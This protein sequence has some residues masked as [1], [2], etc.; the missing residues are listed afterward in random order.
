[1]DEC[2]RFEVRIS[3]P[4]E[5]AAG[6]PH[7]LGFRP[8]ESVVLIGLGGASGGRVGLTVR[9]DIP[10]PRHAA[11][12]AG[13]LAR[14]VATDEPA[15]VLVAV[16]SEA[17]DVPA[18]PGGVDLP[19]RDLVHELVVTLAAEDIP[20]RD[21]LLVR[22]GRWWS[23]DCPHPCCAPD[24]GTPLPAGVSELEAASVAAGQV[25]AQSRE[26]L[27]TRL[28]SL[29]RVDREVVRAASLT[30]AAAR[31]ARAQDAG[32]TSWS[33]RHGARS[34]RRSSSARSG[35]RWRRPA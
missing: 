11:A 23:Y 34:R 14:G 1:V 25:L 31:F 24:A 7:L 15:A 9:A 19:H 13:A 18:T 28:D 12:R 26:E 29:D 32:W 16:V 4:G 21:A 10:P 17:P 20:V 30:M 27:Q 22:G 6:L 5:V 2:E 3:D 35:R 33:A 8:V